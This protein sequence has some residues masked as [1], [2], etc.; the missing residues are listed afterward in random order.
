MN[1]QLYRGATAVGSPVAG[2][3]AAISFGN[4]TVAGTYTVVA[5]NASTNCS[6]SMSGSTTITTIPRPTSTITVNGT[7]LQELSICEGGSATLWI[8]FTGTGPF[9]YSLNGAAIV[10]NTGYPEKI[11][12]SPSATTTYQISSLS[13]TKCT[14]LD[15]DR[16]G[17]VTVNVNP[18]PTLTSATQLDVCSNS[19]VN[20]QP[21]SSIDGSTFSWSRAVVAGISNAGSSGSGS[22]V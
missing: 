5:T 4:Q 13:D 2:T 7:S 10:T 3:N 16:I 14:A 18:L 22:I 11:T 15:A 12:I 6:R 20:Y 9:Q 19:S 17:T 1:Y 8:N 21:V